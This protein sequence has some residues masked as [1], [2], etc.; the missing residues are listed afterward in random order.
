MNAFQWHSWAPLEEAIFVNMP[1]VGA[2]VL[3]WIPKKQTRLGFGGLW[4]GALGS[5]WK[6]AGADQAE[7]KGGHR[8]QRW[9]GQSPQVPGVLVASSCPQ[10]SEGA[11]TVSCC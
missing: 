1:E 7:G 9:L 5:P 3:G 4:E 11:G 10:P 2:V 6:E 8:G